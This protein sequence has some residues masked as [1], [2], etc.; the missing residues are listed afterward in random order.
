M[1]GYQ[2]PE[3]ALAEELRASEAEIRALVDSMQQRLSQMA[4]HHAELSAS[5]EADVSG[6][7]AEEA[8]V[9]DRAA[10]IRRQLQEHEAEMEAVTARLRGLEAQAAALPADIADLRKR[11]ADRAAAHRE[12]EAAAGREEEDVGYRLAELRRGTEAFA[13]LGLRFETQPDGMVRFVFTRIRAAAPDD[14]FSFT[15][16]VHDDDSFSTL[17]CKPEV[18]DLAD[19]MEVLNEGKDFSGFVR[20]MRRAFKAMV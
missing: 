10:V 2:A 19:R 6:L 12:G 14:E 20:G 7:A 3:G 13:G 1:A 17:E 5:L 18:P 9:A 15:L 16:Q 8:G 11:E 4:E